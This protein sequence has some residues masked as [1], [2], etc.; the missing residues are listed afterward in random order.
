MIIGEF[1]EYFGTPS[2]ALPCAHTETLSATSERQMLATGTLL[3]QWCVNKGWALVW[4][5]GPGNP[6]PECQSGEKTSACLRR[7]IFKRQVNNLR[8]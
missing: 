7:N 5:I 6:A 4:A 1:D 2:G 8:H 3:R